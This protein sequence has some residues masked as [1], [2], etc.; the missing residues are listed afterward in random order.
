VVQGNIF[1]GLFNKIGHLALIRTFSLRYQILL[2]TRELKRLEKTY[3]VAFNNALRDTEYAKVDNTAYRLFKKNYLIQKELNGQK[4]RHIVA[5]LINPIGFI[6]K[7]ES[8]L[9]LYD[10]LCMQREYIR[11]KVYREIYT[12][13]YYSKKRDIVRARHSLNEKIP[14][15]PL[16]KKFG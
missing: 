10:A 11:T 5:K 14:I 4:I 2:K 13:N 6:K 12:K 8:D 3:K 9:A 15:T 16:Q 7:Q 1:S